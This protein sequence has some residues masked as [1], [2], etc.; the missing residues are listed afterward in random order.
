VR[1]LHPQPAAAAAHEQR[2]GTAGQAAHGCCRQVLLPA[3]M[4]EVEEQRVGL[5]GCQQGCLA[6]GAFS[7]TGP[8]SC[9]KRTVGIS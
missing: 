9:R 1:P 5:Q 4:T 8:L 2:C 3:A 7:A 6:G